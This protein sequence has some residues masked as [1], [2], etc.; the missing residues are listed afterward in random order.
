[1][2]VLIFRV[3]WTFLALKIGN[4]FPGF[5]RFFPGIPSNPQTI[6][7]GSPVIPGN[8]CRKAR[9]PEELPG[10][11]RNYQEIPRNPEEFS[12]NILGS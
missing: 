8:P 6:L 7:A 2:L 4:F 1:M 11:L 12:G 3:F 5:S 9:N 10:I